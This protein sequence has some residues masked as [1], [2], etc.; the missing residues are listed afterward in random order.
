LEQSERLGKSHFINTLG[1]IY[2]QERLGTQFGDQYADS[3]GKRTVH[4]PNI[5]INNRFNDFRSDEADRIGAQQLTQINQFKTADSGLNAATKLA[6]TNQWDKL[7]SDKIDK[8]FVNRSQQLDRI[9]QINAQQE[10]YNSQNA[11]Q[12]N[13]FA[14]NAEIARLSAK[15]S[16]QQQALLTASNAID[17]RVA[18]ERAK[19]NRLGQTKANLEMQATKYDEMAATATDEKARNYY[20]EMAAKLRHKSTLDMYLNVGGYSVPSA[21]KGAKLRSTTEQMLIDKQKLVARAVE[22][23]NDNTMKILLKAM[24]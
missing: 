19:L 18:E 11:N 6:G 23:I 20:R 9:A 21:K 22:K 8:Q 15:N 14:V 2:Q 10:L 4:T 12:K 17:N 1:R 5:K 16:A 7:M 24:S 13:E 3:L